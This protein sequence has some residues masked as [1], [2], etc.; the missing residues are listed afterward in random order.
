MQIRIA[1]DQPWD[2]PADVLAVPVLADPDWSGPLGE[3]DRRTAGQIQAQ[4]AFGELQTKR[5]ST[6]VVPGGELR[7]QRVLA[8][9]AGDAAALDR[10]AVL[11]LGQSIERRLGGRA[12]RTLAVALDPLAAAL[13][14]GAPAA[15]ELIARGVE[16]GSFEPAAIYRDEVSDARPA[17]MPRPS[18][19]PPSAAGSS[20]RGRTSPA[21]SRTVPPT[22]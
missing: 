16:E 12:V 21:A 4:L 11:H 3:I 22:T 6:A 7:A 2:V 18:R 1:T 8:V 15:A 13:D 19:P 14:G 5:Y 17:A 20:A 9:G 10:E